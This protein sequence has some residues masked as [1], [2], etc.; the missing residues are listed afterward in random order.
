MKDSL[1][2]ML[3]ADPEMKDALCMIQ[4]ILT[5]AVRS[6][7]AGRIDGRRTSVAIA[8]SGSA[9]GPASAWMRTNESVL[10]AVSQ[11]L[12]YPGIDF[13]NS[14]QSVRGTNTRLKVLDRFSTHKP[15]TCWSQA[16]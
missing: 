7:G 11:G 9:N 12:F 6:E 14:Y 15:E 10:N 3:I 13:D 5:R 16:S 1:I 4:T 8:A 2:H